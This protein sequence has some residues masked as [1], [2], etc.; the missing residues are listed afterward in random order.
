MIH[1]RVALCSHIRQFVDTELP[2]LYRF[3]D[4][5]FMPP[6]KKSERGRDKWRETAEVRFGPYNLT[7]SL[8]GEKPPLGLIEL[9]YMGG[10]VTGPLDTA[11]WNR[12][13]ERIRG[14]SEYANQVKKVNAH[15]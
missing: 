2:G 14:R 6:E 3:D 10:N 11:T 9:S 4:L 13:G 8:P 12:I 7:V 1:P 15:G 5:E